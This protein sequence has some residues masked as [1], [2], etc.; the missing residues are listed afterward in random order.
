MIRNLYSRFSVTW[1]YG[2]SLK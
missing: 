2:I 1:C